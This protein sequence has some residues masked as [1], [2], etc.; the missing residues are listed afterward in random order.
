LIGFIVE[1][2]LN[3]ITIFLNFNIF[4]EIITT[5]KKLL[6]IC[7]LPLSLFGQIC[8]PGGNI[9]IYS[10]Y[11]GGVLNIN[12]DQNIPNLK[13][14]VVTYEG[15]TINLSGTYVN[16]VTEVYYAG[17]NGQNAHCGTLINTSINGA[18]GSAATSVNLYPPA[19]MSDP[20]GYS[21]IICAYSCDNNSNQG[22]CNTVAQVEDFFLNEF[23]GSLY[24]HYVQYGCWSGTMALSSGGNCCPAVPFNATTENTPVSCNGACDGTATVIPQGGTAPYIYNW[25]NGSTNDVQTGLCAGTYTVTVTD[26]NGQ[27]MLQT[28]TVTEPAAIQATFVNSIETVPC[29]A[30]SQVTPSG[31]V[32][33][34]TYMWDSGNQTSFTA[35]GLCEGTQC[36]T[37][38]DSEGCSIEACTTI[39][40]VVGIE[41]YKADN[42]AIIEVLDLMGRKTHFRPNTPMI[43]VFSDG[44][45]QCVVK[46]E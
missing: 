22:G 20:N 1:I 35:S 11:D 27:S 9:M 36:V 8:N 12:V 16:N 46:F 4:R 15:T 44:T 19:T 31:G 5:M 28:V 37:I 42:K 10:N 41:E 18:P 39:N 30:T 6:L 17:Y 14:G 45:R 33:I 26:N 7:L 23:G 24:A 21:F 29:N 3:Y 32:P 34:Y 43:V 38:T 2:T 40:S 13:I 25:S